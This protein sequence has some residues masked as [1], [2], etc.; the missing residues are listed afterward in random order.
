MTAP[1]R[2]IPATVPYS[3]SGV[4]SVMRPVRPSAQVR[5]PAHIDGGI[6]DETTVGRDL[7]RER[8]AATGQ[9][10]QLVDTAVAFPQQRV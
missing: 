6:G 1:P 2:E 8:R 5:A 9:A 3:P 10:R 4:R 7:V